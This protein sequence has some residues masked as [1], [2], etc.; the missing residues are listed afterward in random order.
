MSKSENYLFDR[1][2]LSI[3]TDVNGAPEVKLY[4]NGRPQT[5]TQQE[6]EMLRILVERP[7]Q[8]IGTNALAA[9][10]CGEDRADEGV[11]HTA[12]KGLRRIFNDT[13]KVSEFIKNDRKQGYCFLKPL[14]SVRNEELDQAIRVQ[15]E[16]TGTDAALPVEEKSS[17]AQP[18]AEEKPSAVAQL[19]IGE[20]LPGEGR[21]EGSGNRIPGIMARRRQAHPVGRRP[22]RSPDGVGLR[23]G[24]RPRVG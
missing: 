5:L 7:G 15:A 12:V 1:F 22:R 18:P 4:S 19:P 21:L 6:A 2:C 8:F 16:V 20:Q 24:G 10:V 3:R 9:A 17:E 11:I 14:R 23:R 13:A